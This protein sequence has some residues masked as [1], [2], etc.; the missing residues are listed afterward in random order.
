MQTAW[1][2][3]EFTDWTRVQK[4][5]LPE[6]FEGRQLI[7]EAPTGSGKTLAYLLP[8]LKDAD[9]ALKQTQVVIAVSTRELAMQVLQEVQ[10]WSADSTLTS[11]AMI[12]GAN[13]KRQQEKLKKKPA[14]IVGTPGRLMEHISSRKL[15]MH[16][17]QSLIL[18]EAD[19]LFAPEHIESTENL[20]KSVQRDCRKMI[21]S[22][23]IPPRVEKLAAEKLDDPKIIRIE[24]D[25]AFLESMT[26]VYIEAPLR[27][28]GNMLLRL[29]AV[30]GFRGIVFSNDRFELEKLAGRQEGKKRAAAVLHAET[31]REDREKAIKSVRSGEVSVLLATDV[32][33]RGLDLPDLS[34]VVQM[35]TA[36]DLKQYIHRAG[37]TARAGNTGTVVSIV[38]EGEK[39]RLEQMTTSL[40]IPLQK[41]ILKQGAL[42]LEG[43]P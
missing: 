9:P 38:T 4:E 3:H 14:V 13:V 32:A 6:A 43:K 5:V 15:K 18:D 34:F 10:A 24:P 11:A 26:H 36:N 17:V 40:H 25:Q 37:R 16:Q 41:G 19:Q 21:V 31:S 22:A 28:K 23:T 35:D 42:V 20:M 29:T 7:V 12:G 2:K 39:E 1:E 30:E 33:S 27:E 8:A